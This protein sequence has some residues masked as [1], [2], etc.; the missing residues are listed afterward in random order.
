MKK[1]ALYIGLFASALVMSCN[2]DNV[3]TVA[4]T[5]PADASSALVRYVHAAP[6][7]R[8]VYN[9]ADS[10]NILVNGVKVNGSFLTFSTTGGVSPGGVV[11]GSSSNNGYQVVAAGTQTTKLSLYG[12]LTP[13]SASIATFNTN[14]AAGTMTTLFITDSG[15][16]AVSDAV[17]TKPAAGTVQLRFL[18]VAMNDTVGKTV[19]VF[20]ARK[21][22]NLAT[23]VKIGALTDF[24]SLPYVASGVGA[25]SMSDT[26]YVRR[27]GSPFV[28]AQMNTILLNDAR[29]YTVYYRG[30]G[31]VATAGTKGRHLAYYLHQ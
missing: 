5:T 8:A 27:A 24:V 21:N 2:K 31:G 3:Q 7:F 4:L 22:G 13:D 28:L 17:A 12:I 18:H 9:G 19:D 25:T 29:S 10:F 11:P 15:R 1:T 16:I 6:N 30:N 14:L 23:G 26:I 20:S